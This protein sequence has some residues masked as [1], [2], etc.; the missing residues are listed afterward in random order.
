MTQITIGNVTTDILSYSGIPVCTTSQLAEFYECETSNIQK[1][2][3]SNLDRFKEGVH[4]F[5]LEGDSLKQ[6]KKGLSTN[7]LE[8]LKFAPQAFLWTE[9]G[10]ARHAKMLT[11]NPAWDVWEK[12]EDTYFKVKD[13]VK[14]DQHPSTVAVEYITAAFKVAELLNI[15]PHLAQTEIVK[16]AKLITGGDFGYLLKLSPAQ[17]D[18]EDDNIWKEPSAIAAHFGIT[19]ANMPKG[20][21]G[22]PGFYVNCI[23]GD[24]GLQSRNAA[25]VWHP[26]AKGKPFTNNNHWLGKKST[27][28]GYNYRWKL[29]AIE[30]LFNV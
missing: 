7:S 27:K 16:E 4:F 18:I 10:A 28:D 24:A 26:T 20:Y 23:L 1:N 8:P 2:Y 13:L 12:L 6:F 14:Y 9:K 21:L 17:S 29:S 5:K 30:H 15:T 19:T 22:N 25:K 3:L 11:G